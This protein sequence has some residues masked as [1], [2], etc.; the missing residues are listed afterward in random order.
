MTEPHKTVYI[1]GPISTFTAPLAAWL[2]AKGWHVHIATKS[3]LNLFTLSSLDLA[4]A[5]KD[6]LEEVFGTRNKFKAFQDR[7]KFLDS[8]EIPRDTKYDALIFCGLPPN[9]DDARVPRAPWAAGELPAVAKSLKGVPVFMISSL[10]GG[11]QPDMVVPEE[12]EFERRKP[13]SYWEKICQNY[14]LKLIEGLSK[15]EASWYLVR[16]PLITGATAN[17]Y[18]FACN[19][20]SNL[21]A[22]LDPESQITPIHQSTKYNIQ[23]KITVNQS[24]PLAHQPDAT[25]WFLPIDIT[26]YMFWRFLEDD[27]RPRICNFVSTQATLNREWLQHL[28][29]ALELKEIVPTHQKDDLNLPLVLKKLL[30][31]NVQVKT[32]NLFEVAGRY[33]LRPEK[34]NQEY[35]AKIVQAG[36]EKNWGRHR[37]AAPAQ[38]DFT[39]DLANYY[40]E[41]FVPNHLDGELLKKITQGSTTVG[42]RLKDNNSLGW[43]LKSI[44]TNGD[45]T[46]VDKVYVQ[47]YKDT[48]DKPRVCFHLTSNTMFRLAQGKLPLHKGLIL[49]QIEVEGPLLDTI[50][51]SQALSRFMSDH[52]LKDNPLKEKA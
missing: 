49:K 15:V 40:F 24:V 1:W 9:F 2:V 43:I 45:K 47:R 11:V 7:L 14:E 20:L 25:L 30:L 19:G 22:A 26:V 31:D 16:L 52:P 32:R 29:Q 8:N 39:P 5:A 46:F 6:A 3:S 17:G 10:W 28:A 42:F 48:S 27:L 51:V 23:H 50:R 34:L 37:I 21:F 44:Q 12:M 41:Q 36:R 33:Q 18:S 4:S 38:L 35:F 13:Y